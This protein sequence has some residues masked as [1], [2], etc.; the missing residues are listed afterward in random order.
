M[1]AAKLT[2][3]KTKGRLCASTVER[4]LHQ[5][6]RGMWSDSD[7]DL[8]DKTRTSENT[9][10]AG[11]AER[12]QQ[13]VPE[14]SAGD[15]SPPASWGLPKPGK[16]KLSYAG[17]EA[18]HRADS[19]HP[20]AVP[21]SG[22]LLDRPRRQQHASIR[23]I[24]EEQEEVPNAAVRKLKQQRASS[25]RQEKEL[26]RWSTT[27]CRALRLPTAAGP[28]ADEQ[29][30]AEGLPGGDVGK[31]SKSLQFLKEFGGSNSV[32]MGEGDLDEA[33]KIE[34]KSRID[35]V[36][37]ELKDAKDAQ[38][39]FDETVHEIRNMVYPHLDRFQRRQF[40]TAAFRAL[41]VGVVKTQ[42]MPLPELRSRRKATAA[43]LKARRADAKALGVR[44]HIDA[45]GSVQQAAR[46]RLKL[47]AQKKK[48]KHLRDTFKHAGKCS[49]SKL[50]SNLRRN[51]ARHRR[52]T[53]Q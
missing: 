23:R 7:D 43:A 35:G 28:P 46:N 47:L 19:M 53:A 9:P 22:G 50:A 8:V 13:D 16:K 37:T 4:L 20:T 1:K 36:E 39:V 12:M 3:K 2:G 11:N 27:R 42:R 21:Y 24:A 52:E 10:G 14:V 48:R 34:E 31:A 17:N 30:A 38:R 25:K 32:V 44:S 51:N 6:C 40:V 49:G 26:R 33:F 29:R 45:Q 18:P 41:G 5:R 15:I